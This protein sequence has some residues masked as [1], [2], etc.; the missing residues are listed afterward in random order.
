MGLI[1]GGYVSSTRIRNLLQAGYV[2]KA[3]RDLGYSYR[4]YGRVITG[5]AR[6]KRLGFPTANLEV[7]ESICIPGDG[8]YAGIAGVG[9]GEYGCAINIGDN[10]TFHDPEISVEAHILDF[11]GEIYGQ[12]MFLE[13]HSKIRD[14]LAFT[15]EEMLKRQMVEDVKETR[16][17]LAIDSGSGVQL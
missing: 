2:D 10:P 4:L 8:V 13:F 14:E 7:P 1:D 9:G 15:S 12:D 3:H 5:A 17:R 6:G 11:E 16:R